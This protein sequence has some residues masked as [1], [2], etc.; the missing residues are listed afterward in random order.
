MNRDRWKKISQILDVA[1]SYPGEKRTTYIQ[2]VCGSDP[3]LLKE[4]NDLLQSLNE[5]GDDLLEN[6]LENNVALMQSVLN[7][8]SGEETDIYQKGKTIGRWTLFELIGRG[9]MGSVYRV[10]RIGEGGIHQT[11]ALKIIHKSLVTSSHIERFRLEQQILSRLEH[12]EIARFIDSG[13]TPEGVPYMVM[14]YVE[15]TPILDYCDSHYLS[16]KQR[17]E[18]FKT[19]CRTVQYAHKSLVVHRDLKSENILVTPEGQVKILDF[20]IAKL[21]DPDLYEFSRIETLPGIRLLSLEYASPEQIRGEPVTTSSDLYSLGILLYK[22][23]TGL[24]PFDV[25][26]HSYREVEKFVLEKDP[27]LPSNRFINYTDGGMKVSIARMRKEEPKGLIK[28]TRGD[29]DAI[30]SQNLRK[31]PERRYISVEALI[32]D[33]DRHQ[34][35]R[36]ISARPDAFGYRLRKFVY[37]HR[38]MVSAVLVVLLVITAGIIATLWQANQARKYAVQAELQA[39][40]AEQVTDFMVDLFEAGDPDVAQGADI[41]FSEILNRGV[42][43]AMVPGQD[44]MLQLPLLSALSR[45]YQNLGEY[46]KS[47]DLLNVAL[48]LTGDQEPSDLLL[49]AELQNQQGINQRL[50]GNLVL[51]DSLHRLTLHTRRS[52][53]GENDPST[54]RS[55]LALAGIQAYISR[56]SNAADSMY[57]DVIDRRRSLNDPKDEILAEALSNLGYI[58]IRKGD[59]SEALNLYLEASE[60]MRLAFGEY[61]PDRLAALSSVAYVH[62]KLGNYDLAE[63]LRLEAIEIRIKVL[64]EDHPQVGLSYFYLSSLLYDTGRFEEALINS[65]KAVEIIQNAGATHPAYPDLM[66]LQARLYH[67]TENVFMAADGYRKASEICIDNRGIDSP[68]CSRLNFSAAEFFIEQQQYEAAAEFLLPSYAVL[69]KLYERGDHQRDRLEEMFALVSDY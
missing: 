12:P 21:L 56:N 36:P 69:Q 54:V 51:A 59:Y 64:G 4:V 37:R 67:K 47:S 13:I 42:E 50:L 66:A 6:H 60:I 15:G 41:S 33:I 10:E 39:Q 46:E 16:I 28:K 18:L 23:L 45:V 26:D 8:N 25:D 27:P 14:E 3:D 38:W 9:G 49:I 2:D 30:V 22:L 11:G 1:L 48:H 68:A 31:D 58:K 53:L 5:P 44:V 24:H 17:L 63:Q 35:T 52:I 34:K 40:R 32:A 43:Q 57:Q 29:L 62:H 61:H 19:V 65:L 55:L 20:G 7:E